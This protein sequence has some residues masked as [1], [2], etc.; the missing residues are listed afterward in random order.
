M[1]AFGTHILTRQFGDDQVAVPS[2]RN[3]P[4]PRESSAYHFQRLPFQVLINSVV[5]IQKA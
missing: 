2:R 1:R 5:V 3:E 4:V